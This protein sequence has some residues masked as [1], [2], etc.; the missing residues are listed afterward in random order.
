LDQIAHVGVSPA[1]K[2]FSKNCN[3]CD[4]GT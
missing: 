3:L 1:V 2:L 4:H